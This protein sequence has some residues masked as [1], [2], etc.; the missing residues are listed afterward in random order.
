MNNNNNN[1]SWISLRDSSSSLLFFS[2]NYNTSTTEDA[3]GDFPTYMDALEQYQNTINN[4][5]DD[6]GEHP[7]EEDGLLNPPSSG[8]A[9]SAG[10]G[11]GGVCFHDTVQEL[12]ASGHIAQVPLKDA[13]DDRRYDYFNNAMTT[14]TNCDDDDDNMSLQSL[15]LWEDDVGM[16][17]SE[18]TTTTTTEEDM[19]LGTIMDQGEEEQQDLREMIQQAIFQAWAA[20]SEEEDEIRDQTT[21][22]SQHRTNSTII[23]RSRHPGLTLQYVLMCLFVF[24]VF[25]GGGVGGGGLLLLA[26]V[27]E[28]A[29]KIVGVIRSTHSNV[30]C[31]SLFFS[32]IFS[33]CCC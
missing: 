29:D 12:S 17:H 4:D 14:T 23:M 1:S 8:S 18:P 22:A 25:L 26:C 9:T 30:S 6:D 2:P 19:N 24:W 28:F 7:E 15:N 10:T 11:G 5:D 33:C 13:S 3:D 32:L 31:L 27:I 16:V 21:S 20:A